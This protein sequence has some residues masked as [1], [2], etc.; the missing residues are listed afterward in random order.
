[1]IEL[2]NESQKENRLEMIRKALKDK[3][4]MTYSELEDSG[5]LESF[6]E[7]REEEM[8]AYFHEAQNKAWEETKAA[9]LDFFDP[10]YDETSSPM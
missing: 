7:G 9:F 10:S 4:P 5:Q 1:M 3:A 6:L 8:M 2:A